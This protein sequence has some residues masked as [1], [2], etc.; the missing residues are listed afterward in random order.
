MTLIRAVSVK[1]AIPHP[2]RRLHGGGVLKHCFTSFN[3]RIKKSYNRGESPMKRNCLQDLQQ[4]LCHWHAGVGGASQ[5]SDSAAVDTGS[6]DSAE[7][8]VSCGSLHDRDPEPDRRGLQGG[9]PNVTLTF[10]FAS[11]GDPSPG[12][13]R[14]A[15]IA[16]CLSRQHLQMNA[17]RRF[18]AMTDK[19]LTV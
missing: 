17:L 15:R 19:N 16:T 7:L 12:R 5:S 4:R 11:S 1:T 14:K 13:S 9:C 2:I 8:T 3:A 10:N 18:R 6:A